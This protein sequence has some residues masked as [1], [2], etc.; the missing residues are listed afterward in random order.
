MERIN[1]PSIRKGAAHLLGGSVVGRGLNFSL[2]TLLGRVLGPDSLG[3]LY[4]VLSTAQTFEITT[5]GGVD[6]GLQCELTGNSYSEKTDVE[7]KKVTEAAIRWVT[8][9]SVIGVF[10]LFIWI[11]IIRGLLPSDLDNNHILTGLV[12]IAM[13]LFESLG[14]L[15]WDILIVY[16]K[17]KL[18]AL[19]QGFFAPLKLLGSLLLSY[20]IGI[21]GALIGYTTI[22]IIQAFWLKLQIKEYLPERVN[23]L[24]GWTKSFELV[25]SGISLYLSNAASALVFLPLM[26]FLGSSSGMNEVGFLRVGQLL[27]QL[28]TLVPGA[29]S[30]LLFLKLRTTRS[31]VSNTYS[32]IKAMTIVWTLGVIG[33]FAYLILDVQ[34]INILLGPDFME[35]VGPT[36]VLVMCSLID[37]YSQIIYTPILANKKTLMFSVVQIM[38]AIM[39]GIIGFVLTPTGGIAGYLLAKL[40][41][42]WIPLLIY[43]FNLASSSE[44]RHEISFQVLTLMILT[45]LCWHQSV[46]LYWI[47][48]ALLFSTTTTIMNIKWLLSKG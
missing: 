42:S 13:C 2:N 38:S 26:A 22:S 16:G 20:I 23:Y 39:A 1:P 32:T 44:A 46:N 45:P 27:S 40:C 8:V 17:S 10:V 19:R 24:A 29:I 18:V 35:S 7:K 21:E 30:P 37:S 12:V 31:E 47:A 11:Y 4:L 14:G 33:L 28:F 48:F 9:S 34:I 15:P 36:R 43:S 41:F 25:K 3:L 5:R 6:Y